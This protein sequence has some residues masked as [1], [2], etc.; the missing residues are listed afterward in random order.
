MCA[1]TEEKKRLSFFITLSFSF[2]QAK[3]R[4][5]ASAPPSLRS[6]P[7]CVDGR[8][9]MTVALFLKNCRLGG[10]LVQ[11]VIMETVFR[12]RFRHTARH[13]RVCRPR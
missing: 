4:G 2:M 12:A 13:V 5:A 7:R 11:I 6:S 3:N 10:S 8:E 9:R 1:H